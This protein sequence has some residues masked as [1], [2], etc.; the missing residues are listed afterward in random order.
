MTCHAGSGPHSAIA[1]ERLRLPRIWSQLQAVT[2]TIIIPDQHPE[3]YGKR[4]EFYPQ[5][6]F[7]KSSLTVIAGALVQQ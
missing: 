3:S 2:I 1:D 4:K 6:R 7:I 5:R